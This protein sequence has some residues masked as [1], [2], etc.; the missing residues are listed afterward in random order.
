MRKEL[1][2]C[3]RVN[4]LRKYLRMTV[5]KLNKRNRIEAEKWQ[6]FITQHFSDVDKNIS[7]S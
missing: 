7:N 5:G 3:I 2:V 1:H 6:Y 4:I